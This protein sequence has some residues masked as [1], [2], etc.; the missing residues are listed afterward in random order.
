MWVPVTT[1]WHVIGMRMKGD[2]LKIW[3]TAA[4]ILS[5]QSRTADMWWYTSF[6]VVRGANNSSP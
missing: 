4:N 2:G 3:G 6:G 1:S 5:E